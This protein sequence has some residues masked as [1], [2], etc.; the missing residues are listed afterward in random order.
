MMKPCMWS[1]YLIDLSPEEALRTFARKEWRCLEFS[2]EHSKTLLDRGDP[3]VIG[4]QFKRFAA[5]LGVELPQGHLILHADVTV[6]DPEPLLNDLKRWLDLYV[7]LGIRSAVI[8]PGGNHLKIR[9]ADP[10]ILRERRARS[11]GILADH[12]KG[13]PVTLCIENTHWTNTAYELRSIIDAVGGPN[14]A[15]CLDTGHLHQGRGRQREFILAAG[16]HLKAIHVADNEGQDD[17][18]LMPFGK[19][20]VN[21]QEVVAA[22][23]EIRFAGPFNLEIPGEI[24]CPLAV[25]L[26]KLDY[27][28]A[29]VQIML[30]EAYD[31]V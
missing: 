22:L 15:I 25:R 11:F 10:R 19:G 24:H 6:D 8:H 18:H 1:S 14:L 9:G 29:V 13:T 21:W 23:K 7:A 27:I 16:K 20:S 4:R 31:R 28:R 12:V 17:Q 3:A 5:D 26:A 30:E 2:C